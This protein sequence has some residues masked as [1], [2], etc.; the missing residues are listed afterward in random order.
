[1]KSFKIF[2]G[3]IALAAAT[4][5]ATPASM[6]QENNNRDAYGRIVK[7][8]Y[9]TNR[10]I[11]NTFI[12]VGGGASIF[13]LDPYKLSPTPSIDAYLGKWFTPSIGA[14]LGYQGFYSKF[15]AEKE[16]E[17]GYAYIHGDMLWNLSNALS[18]YKQTRFWDLV[19]YLHA[20]YFRAYN[21]LGN[22]FADNELAAGVGLLNK[23]RISDRV[24]LN[25]DLRGTAVNGRVAQTSGGLAILASAT[26]G[27]SINIGKPYFSRVSSVYEDIVSFTSEQISEI[28]SHV[29]ALEADKLVLKNKNKSLEEA[30]RA[31]E[32]ENQQL[33]DE[34]ENEM[35]ILDN[36]SPA[37]FYFDIGKATLSAKELEHLDFYVRNILASINENCKMTVTIMGSADKNTGSTK[38][39]QALCEQRANHVF[40][41]LTRTYG[42]SPENIFI[43]T[44]IVNG[45]KAPDLVRSVIIGL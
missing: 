8:P 40:N 38:R 33:R 3:A 22:K 28:E 42:M 5:A 14:R 34:V 9:E 44:E 20:G 19:P 36:I 29:L 6:A 39:N 16:G 31:L 32:N 30:N 10:F 7:G 15:I 24:C 13:W 27:V 11:D 25:L 21:T 4:L 12:G 41:L 26:F 18:G 43:K 35:L 37:T 23:M 1:M 2:M 45:K 17:F